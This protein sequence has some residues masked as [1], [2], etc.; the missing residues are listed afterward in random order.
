MNEQLIYSKLSLLSS[1]TLKAELL[2]YLDY[3]LSKQFAEKST[4]KRMPRFGSAKGTFKMAADFD[5]PLEDFK[6]YMP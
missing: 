6:D 4:S 5:A 1:E 2:Q 3:L